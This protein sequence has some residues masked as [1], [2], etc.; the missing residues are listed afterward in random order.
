MAYQ[1]NTG[2]PPL[3]RLGGGLVAQFS[4][5]EHSRGRGAGQFWR[6]KGAGS[7]MLL[8]NIG[9]AMDVE[10]SPQG[11][12]ESLRLAQDAVQISIYY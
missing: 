11:K 6:S 8:K 2:F 10:E 9:A 5:R 1:A 3:G 12:S 7:N 4:S